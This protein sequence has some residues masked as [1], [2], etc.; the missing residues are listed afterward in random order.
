MPLNTIPTPCVYPIVP[1]SESNCSSIS[2]A[3][4]FDSCF[5]SPSNHNNV[6]QTIRSL[7]S[8]LS[9]ELFTELIK[10]WL[11]QI[12]ISNTEP[13]ID[14]NS[15]S[16]SGLQ[17][18][19]I[20]NFDL[21]GNFLTISSKTL[22]HRNKTFFSDSSDAEYTRVN[23]FSQDLRASAQRQE[24]ASPRLSTIRSRST[25]ATHRPDVAFQQSQIIGRKHVHLHG[26]TRLQPLET[27]PE[28]GTSHEEINR[29]PFCSNLSMELLRG[30]SILHPFH[31][32][33][34]SPR[35]QHTSR[36]YDTLPPLSAVSTI[37][38]NPQASLIPRLQAPNN[39]KRWFLKTLY[40]VVLSISD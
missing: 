38:T 34:P 13:H 18:N 25:S 27:R 3:Y 17:I 23:S 9:Q 39:T 14:E 40:V 19:G 20:K 4:P 21:L 1:Y 36:N 6:S 5:Q 37:P 15:T 12:V 16:G 2:C 32:Y 10:P 29:G 22:Q 11:L 35:T 33:N 30:R 31:N 7:M 26:G 8:S 28:S 24:S